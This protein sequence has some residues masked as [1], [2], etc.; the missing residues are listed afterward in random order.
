MLKQTRQ[1]VY[2]QRYIKFVCF[3]IIYEATYSK[4]I[5]NI[6]I[7]N[8]NKYVIETFGE[9]HT[10][11]IILIYINIIYTNYI[12]SIPSVSSAQHEL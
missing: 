10:N 4:T 9:T 11:Y 8:N 12:I 7:I 5:I 6:I 2:Y 1:Y 3:E